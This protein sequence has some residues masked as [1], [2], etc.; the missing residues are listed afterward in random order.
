MSFNTN[1]SSHN[2]KNNVGS[3]LNNSISE[4]IQENDFPILKKL[5]TELAT[6]LDKHCHYLKKDKDIIDEFLRENQKL[7]D[8][9]ALALKRFSE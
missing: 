7:F 2:T 9:I 8:N 5:I 3:N 6:N 1:I 4:E